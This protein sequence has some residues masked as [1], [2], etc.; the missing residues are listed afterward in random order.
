MSGRPTRRCPECGRGMALV[1]NVYYGV[2]YCRWGA[3]GRCP[4]TEA[5]ALEERSERIFPIAVG[6]APSRHL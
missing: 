2:R 5:R 6:S 4:L 3:D 1:L